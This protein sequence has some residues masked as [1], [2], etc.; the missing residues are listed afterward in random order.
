MKSLY[1][2]WLNIPSQHTSEILFCI[3][4]YTFRKTKK[5]IIESIDNN[6]D[7]EYLPHIIAF[8]SELLTQQLK[9]LYLPNEV[10]VSR[11]SGMPPDWLTK[12]WCHI[13]E[14]FYFPNIATL[15]VITVMRMVFIVKLW[16]FYKFGSQH[17]GTSQTPGWCRCAYRFPLGISHGGSVS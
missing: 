9:S 17:Y 15:P 7:V 2:S 6:S 5:K 12:W 8:V 13:T 11:Y 14:R 4:F 3:I 16:K 1:S 10:A